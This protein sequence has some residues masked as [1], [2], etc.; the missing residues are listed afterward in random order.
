MIVVVCLGGGI[1]SDVTFFSV[2][3]LLYNFLLNKMSLVLK[4]KQKT[5]DIS[6]IVYV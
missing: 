3:A 6:K 2:C 1:M 4:L 5:K